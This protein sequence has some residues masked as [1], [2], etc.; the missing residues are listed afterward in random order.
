[1]DDVPHGT[2]TFLF[3]DIEGSTRLW[4]VYADSM[5]AAYERHDAILREAAV[6]H[7]GVVYKTIGDAVQMVFATAPGAVAAAATV[8]RALVRD[9]W[10][11][12]EPLRVRMALHTGAVDPDATGD[13]R[14]P[15]LNRLGGML[16]A[17][18]GS[19]ILLSRVTME[20][21]RDHL[22]ETATLRDLGEHRFQD[23]SRPERIFQIEDAGLPHEFAP[24]RTLDTRP[25]NLRAQPTPLIGRTT[26]LEHL[27]DLLAQET[28][29]LVTLTGPGGT[30]KTRLA[31]QL[32]ADLIGVFMVDL[33][34]ITNPDLVAGTV[35][36]TLGVQEQGGD[37]HA[38]LLTR[39]LRD[40]EMLLVLDN[41]EQVIDAAPLVSDLLAT[42]P[43]TTVLVT[44]RTDS[45]CAESIRFRSLPSVS[46]V[47]RGTRMWRRSPGTSR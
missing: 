39:F 4:Q 2:V 11:T 12:P 1:M 36:A 7:G 22:P 47:P 29:R 28:A 32:A 27:R 38:T 44:S 42:C 6:E 15:V 13:Y 43:G 16:D 17:G 41:F 35:M 9:P 14:S 25:N 37:T 33:A 45:I 24:L 21:A 31:C 3:T 10:P 19:Q 8:Q 30:G 18:H 23:L 20:L 34:S 40:R 26:D 5:P 46:P